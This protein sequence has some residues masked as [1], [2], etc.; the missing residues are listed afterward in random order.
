MT[1]DAT[2][3]STP[4]QCAPGWLM[5]TNAVLA[6][7]SM[8][9]IAVLFWK[10]DARSPA[11]IVAILLVFT[12]MAFLLARHALRRRWA[13]RWFLQIPGPAMLVFLLLGA[14]PAV[15]GALLAAASVVIARKRGGS[16]GGNAV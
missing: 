15:I 2:P 12:A 7:G 13:A 3:G 8:G 16:P 4:G 10:V 14:L 1:T 6:A 5:T 9:A 11:A